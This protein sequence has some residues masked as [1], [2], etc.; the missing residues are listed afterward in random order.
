M[1]NLKR[2]FIHLTVLAI[3]FASA[4]YA[5]PE[6]RAVNGS[7]DGAITFFRQGNYYTAFSVNYLL[8]SSSGRY[9]YVL[10]LNGSFIWPTA[11]YDTDYVYENG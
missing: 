7:G 5:D 10:P 1:E 11:F 2:L 8:D 9:S 4:V 6:Y 3:L